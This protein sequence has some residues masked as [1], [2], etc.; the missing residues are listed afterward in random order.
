[1]NF[2]S[3][4]VISIFIIVLFFSKLHFPQSD[5]LL[6]I[7]TSDSSFLFSSS[8]QEKT[9]FHCLLQTVSVS[10]ASTSTLSDRLSSFLNLRKQLRKR[11][12]ASK[13]RKLS[14][15]HACTT[16]NPCSFLHTKWYFIDFEGRPKIPEIEMKFEFFLMC[17]VISFLE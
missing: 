11:K 12:V 3:Y 14:S 6:S 9:S 17:K 16:Q 8:G 13:W 7:S 2:A 10:H 1:M 4:I 15:N 5:K